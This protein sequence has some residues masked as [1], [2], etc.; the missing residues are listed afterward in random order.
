VEVHAS[1]T[2]R[3]RVEETARELVA[4][5]K[6]VYL[7]LLLA[8]RSIGVNDKVR[9]I[10]QA[11]VEVA[12]TKYRVG[13]AAQADVLKVQADLLTLE[14][15]RLD[16][17]VKQHE[18]R[19]RLNALLDRPGDAPLPPL[20]EAWPET[21]TP[22]MDELVQMAIHQQPA[23]LIARRSLAETEARLASAR[24]DAD[25]ELAVWAGYM[26]NVRGVDTFTTGVSTT[27]P[28]FSA[29]R[30]SAAVSAEEAEV[31]A[32]R[33]ALRAAERRA[34]TEVRT[35]VLQVEVADRH[36]RLHA[37]K[38]IP[39]ADLALKSAETA[40]QN[41]RIDLLTVLDAARMVR[42]HHLNHLKYLVEHQRRLTELERVLGVDLV[43]T[44]AVRP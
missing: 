4:G 36:A 20:A 19:A 43:V 41:D 27:L 9:V 3:V 25:P 6:A 33:A 11:M 42:D 24:H 8:N 18:S 44:D 32:Q 31:R 23:V 39:V 30:R 35:L 26:V 17:D 15:E 1:E 2:A 22:S 5:A 14:N 7:D 29:R 34:E 10:L 37:N 16:L 40:Y 28:V 12:D 38:L 13:K 21:Q